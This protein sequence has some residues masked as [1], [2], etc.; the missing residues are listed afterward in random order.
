[1]GRLPSFG[2]LFGRQSGSKN[3]EPAEKPSKRKARPQADEPIDEDAGGLGATESFGMDQTRQTAD[4]DD[5]EDDVPTSNIDDDQDDEGE[6]DAHDA[7][8]T[9]IAEKKDLDPAALEEKFAN[10]KINFAPQGKKA[11][12]A[13]PREIDLSGYQFPGMDLLEEP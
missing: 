10:F 9:Y 4:L 8:G 6:D 11:G 3:A 5:D 1:A 2:D 13:P 12:N 7:P